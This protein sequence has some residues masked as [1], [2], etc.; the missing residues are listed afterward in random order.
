MTVAAKKNYIVDPSWVDNMRA[1]VYS[2]TSPNFSPPL[3]DHVAVEKLMMDCGPYFQR[4]Y[5]LSEHK[6]KSL[7]TLIPQS[8]I[9]TLSALLPNKPA[10][11]V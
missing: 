3:S 5:F 8:A 9:N 11:D 6:I 4:T 7:I 1:V 10:R 2:F